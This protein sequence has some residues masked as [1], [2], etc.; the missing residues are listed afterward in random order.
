[1][2]DGMPR[3]VVRYRRQGERPPDV[4]EKVHGITGASVLEDSG[5]MMLVEAPEQALRNTLAEDDWLISPEV[6]HPVPDTRKKV[7][8]PARSA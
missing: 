6:N 3:F 2:S 5:R 1:M 7:K 4:L 8:S